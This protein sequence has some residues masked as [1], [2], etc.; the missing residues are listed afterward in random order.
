MEAQQRKQERMTKQR[1]EKTHPAKEA[2]ASNAL[3]DNIAT[4]I[5]TLELFIASAES[6]DA[7]CPKCGASFADSGGGG[8]GGGLVGVLR[9]V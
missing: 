5:A 1:K 8:G 9:W 4:E 7:I 6:D 2:T 3:I